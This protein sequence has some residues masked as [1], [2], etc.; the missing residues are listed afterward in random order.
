MVVVF[1]ILKSIVR[2]LALLII[3]LYFIAATNNYLHGRKLQI[4]GPQG[5][6]GTIQGAN[7]C[8]GVVVPYNIRTEAFERRC[9]GL[10]YHRHYNQ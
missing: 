3:T 7:S 2:V 4:Y 1:R 9:F 8:F 6:C 5:W 10:S